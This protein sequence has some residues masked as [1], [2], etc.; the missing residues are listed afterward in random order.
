MLITPFFNERAQKFTTLVIL[1]T[2]KSFA[3][4]RYEL[5]VEEHV[6]KNHIKY[7][8]LGLK[9]PGLSLPAAGH[10][11]FVREYEDLHG[12]YRLVVQGLDNKEY[13][14]AVKISPSEVKVLKSPTGQFMEV[15]TDSA[16]WTDN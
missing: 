7:K 15:V 16:L 3:S 8:V 4:F 6:K 10:A 1:A 5:S 9:A 12:I 11:R 14:C 2:S 13:K